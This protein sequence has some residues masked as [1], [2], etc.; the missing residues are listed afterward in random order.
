MDGKDQYTS[1][2]ISLSIIH[3]KATAPAYGAAVARYFHC[4]CRLLA[5]N[6]ASSIS[7]AFAAYLLGIGW[8]P[9]FLSAFGI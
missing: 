8:M 6:T 9:L 1:E 4:W 5:A 2:T 3:M 7:I